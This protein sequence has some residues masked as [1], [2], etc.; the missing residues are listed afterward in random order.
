MRLVPRT[1]TITTSN[2][3]RFVLF[4]DHVIAQTNGTI[5]YAGERLKSDARVEVQFVRRRA[6]AGC[7]QASLPPHIFDTEA[8]YRDGRTIEREALA[9]KVFEDVTDSHVLP[10]LGHILDSASFTFVYPLAV[11][12][13]DHVVA[14][15]ADAKGITRSRPFGE[16]T[17]NRSPVQHD[18]AKGARDLYGTRGPKE[19]TV[20]A[21]GLELARGLAA[22]HN[23]GVLHRDIKPANILRHDGKWRLG[24]LG[25][26]RLMEETTS[27]YTLAGVGTR[28]YMPPE[29]FALR[30]AT[31]RSDVYSLGCTIYAA[32]HGRP[33]WTDG[34]SESKSSSRSSGC[35][36]RHRPRAR[37]RVDGNDAQGGGRSPER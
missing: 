35:L 21:I 30:P 13:L 4:L 28:E 31:V 17:A 23:R 20:R 12:T 22:M 37:G 36:C 25:I 2:G 32:L 29:I 24:D 18:P 15:V 9:A 5:V 3:A 6:G 1:E 8:W 27:T 26:A 16:P 19:D 11:T 10:L 7:Y 33:P 14:A 34:G